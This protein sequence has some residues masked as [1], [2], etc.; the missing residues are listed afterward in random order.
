MD[1]VRLIRVPR[2]RTVVER[3]GRDR[4]AGIA[5]PVV[6]AISTGVAG[7]AARVV[8]GVLLIEIG[9]RGAVVAG[10]TDTVAVPVLLVAV[11]DP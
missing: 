9:G 3:A 5:E 2:R 6:V 4:E 8:V 10:I 11:G 7:V 1:A